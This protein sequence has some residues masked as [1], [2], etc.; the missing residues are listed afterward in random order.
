MEPETFNGNQ[1]INFFDLSAL[2]QQEAVQKRTFTNWMNSCL[3]RSDPPIL[4]HDLFQD[5]QD[6]LVLAKL[7]E[8]LSSKKVPWDT[9]T[10]QQR[11][12]KLSN[13]RNII[14]FLTNECKVKLIN[15]NPSDIVDGKPAIVLGLIWAIILHFQVG[16]TDD[17]S[18]PLKPSPQN[19]SPKSPVPAQPENPKNFLLTWV[20]TILKNSQD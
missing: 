3:K 1:N 7:L 2:D 10:V 5:V 19:Q 8:I 6:G 15:I 17:S 20:N 9:A 13:I 16:R 12:H 11:T 4:V 18:K 14:D